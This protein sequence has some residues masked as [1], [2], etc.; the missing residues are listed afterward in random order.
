MRDR[1]SHGVH[2]PHTQEMQ[3][4]LEHTPIPHDDVIARG[5][6]TVWYTWFETFHKHSPLPCLFEVGSLLIH[7]C[8]C[9]LC[10]ACMHA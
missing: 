1:Q 6:R 5:H 10:A 8:P 2:A 7:A 9:C 3:A 4:V